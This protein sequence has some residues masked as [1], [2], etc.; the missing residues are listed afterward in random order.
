MGALNNGTPAYSLLSSE[1]MS[2]LTSSGML[3]DSPGLRFFGAYDAS[4]FWA[5][6]WASRSIRLFV[7]FP[8]F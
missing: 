1:E 5:N 2:A 8:V 4:N 7:V 3:S 6:N